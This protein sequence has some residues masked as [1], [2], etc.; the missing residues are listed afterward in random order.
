MKKVIFIFMIMCLNYSV[1]SQ[2]GFKKPENK[3][4]SIDIN[5]KMTK[6]CLL[7]FKKQMNESYFYYLA[8]I[9]VTT[10]GLSLDLKLKEEESGLTPAN[11]TLIGVGSI[12]IFIGFINY[13]DA[14]KWIKRAGIEPV[15]TPD[16][17]TVY[18]K[19]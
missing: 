4:D 1:Y 15:L 6:L 2:Y 11:Y 10:L 14:F 9:G 7:E 8:G 18:I 19:F 12:F 17:A 3:I 16:G 13:I 5:L